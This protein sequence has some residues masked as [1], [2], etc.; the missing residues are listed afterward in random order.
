MHA[1]VIEDD[2]VI[3]L[4]IEEELRDMGFE[5]VDFAATEREAIRAVAR[6][7]PDLITSDGSLSAGSGY[8]AVREIRASNAVPVIFITGDPQSAR[9]CLPD[10]PVLEKPFSVVQ[11]AAAVARVRPPARTKRSASC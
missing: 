4:L 2:A 1:L 8:A 11:L 3:A 7:C 6:R 10:A 5:S 9:R